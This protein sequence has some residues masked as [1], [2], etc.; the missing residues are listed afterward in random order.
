MIKVGLIG[1][2]IDKS[3]LRQ[4]PLLLERI[5]SVNDKGDLGTELQGDQL[6][7][8]LLE[9][10]PSDSE[11][12]SEANAVV[13]SL[14]LQAMRSYSD[15]S[16]SMAYVPL[17]PPEAAM[18]ALTTGLQWMVEEVKPDFMH[19][20]FSSPE[21][22]YQKQQNEFIE[23]LHGQG[24]KTV[25]PVGIPPAFP[26]LLN[27]VVSVADRGFIEA[28]FSFSNPTVI[29]EEKEVAVY[30]HGVWGKQN[31]STEAAST[32]VLGNMIREEIALSIPNPDKPVLLPKLSELSFPTF[33]QEGAESEMYVPPKPSL[34]QKMKWYLT[35]LLSRLMSPTGKV[36]LY[37]KTIRKVSCNGDGLDI[38]ACEFRIASKKQEMAFVCG[39]CGCGDRES[40]FVA[41]NMAKFEK[42]DY[43]YVSCPASMPGFSNYLASTEEWNPSRRKMA[44]EA[45]FGKQAVEEGQQ[46]QEKLGKRLDK[47]FG[48]F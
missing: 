15:I 31:I 27:H 23:K 17:F 45:K 36:P 9:E 19:I 44:I 43:P 28:G 35:S 11:S 42:L 24:C 2:G 41:G 29:I 38:A 26:A 12:N 46:V 5:V 47:R 8:W 37:I 40:V 18:L 6:E 32:M 13:L 16:L 14:L 10:L 20:G 1:G 25:C 4:H 34:L 21:G 30:S 48:W 3:L 7:A 39:A 22:K 33:D